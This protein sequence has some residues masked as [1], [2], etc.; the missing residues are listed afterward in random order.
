MDY[1]FE[2]SGSGVNWSGALASPMLW[3]QEGAAQEG[4]PWWLPLAMIGVL[5]YVMIIRPESRRRAEQTRMLQGIKQNDR[6]WTVGGIFGTVVNVSKDSEALTIRVDDATNT[7]L[8]VLR[9]AISRVE[10]DEKKDG[11]KRDGK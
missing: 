4:L 11:E 8:R 9:S 5:L 3:A 1:L 7:K 10:S 6:V 2:L